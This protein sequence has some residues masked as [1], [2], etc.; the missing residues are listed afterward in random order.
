M[1][2][3][4]QP[5]C[6]YCSNNNKTASVQP[7]P[8]RRTWFGAC[9]KVQCAESLCL[10]R[11]W[12]SHLHAC[13]Y[14]SLFPI[15]VLCPIWRVFGVCCSRRLPFAWLTKKKIII[16]PKVKIG[17]W[18]NDITFENSA[19][20][21]E[22]SRL[23]LTFI[24]QSALLV[25]FSFQLCEAGALKKDFGKGKWQSESPSCWR[26]WCASPACC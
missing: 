3:W 11:Q 13:E 21:I 9:V 7:Q 26:N 20:P 25:S 17:W 10:Q 14:F 19:N 23:V 5:E 6:P 2:C 4:R 22:L 12:T 15:F 18:K 16:I 8:L 1:S 24:I